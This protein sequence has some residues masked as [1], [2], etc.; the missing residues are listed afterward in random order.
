M[1]RLVMSLAIGLALVVGAAAQ[2][3]S[4][5]W[6]ELSKKEVE[7]ILNDSG[8]GQTQVET[9]SSESTYSPTVS[10]TTAGRA[11][12]AS[13]AT[14]GNSGRDTQ[15]AYNQQVFAKYRIRFLSAKPIRAAVAQ[16]VATAQTDKEKQQ[17]IIEMMNP[18]VDRD[19]AGQGIIVVTVD[20]ESND[21]RF[22]Q[23]PRQELA[24]AVAETLK[25]TTYLERKDG[26]RIF[27]ADYR[28]P[29]SDGLGAKFVFPRMLDGQ[30]FL[31][32]N[33]GEVRFVAETG[34]RIRLNMRF[35]VKDMM[36]NG[37]LEY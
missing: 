17:R 22:G 15:G 10:T 36:Y 20:V 35:K 21:Q 1:F 23:P 11:G 12:D 34:K 2:A 19:F 25:N 31:D 26:K 5:P 16:F 29:G 37:H 28:A 4:K 33:S 30:P 14:G 8:W 9:N 3:P 6:T 13:S 27:L 32:E 18:F 7:K 24:S